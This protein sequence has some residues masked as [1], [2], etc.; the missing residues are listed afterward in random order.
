MKSIMTS[1]AAMGL[2]AITSTTQAVEYEFVAADNSP[3]TKTCLYAVTN[4]LTGLKFM[5]TRLFSRNY[6]KLSQ[7]ISCNGLD[8]NHF[9]HTYGAYETSAFLNKRVLPKHR[10]N[11]SVEIID[12][13]KTKDESGIKKVIYIASN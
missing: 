1:I 4:D 5:A 8:I 7:E 9:A 10:I 2:L 11:Y 3:A 13:A 6:R 12:I